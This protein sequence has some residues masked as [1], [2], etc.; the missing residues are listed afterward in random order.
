MAKL[1]ALSLFEIRLWLRTTGFWLTG[2]AIH[3]Y[4]F[5]PWS[6]AYLHTSHAFSERILGQGLLIGGLLILFTSAAVM[7]RDQSERTEELLEAIPA[8]NAEI[9]FARWLSGTA[10][11]LLIGL[12]VFTL[13]GLLILL[14]DGA[15]LEVWPLV[16]FY[17]AHYVPAVLFLHTLGMAAAAWIRQPL[18]LFPLLT[19]IWAGA[20]LGVIELRKDFLYLFHLTGIGHTVLRVSTLAGIF[21]FESHLFWQRMFFTGLT[22]LLIAN[23]I[24]VYRAQRESGD[25][26]R[27][28]RV[29]RS[30]VASSVAVVLVVVS[31]VGYAWYLR[32]QTTTSLAFSR[33]AVF[34]RGP[35]VIATSYDLNV[36]FEDNDRY[37]VHA[38]VDVV[39]ALDEP[40][41]EV[42]LL[43]PG[44]CWVVRDDV[45]G[46]ERAEISAAQ[47]PLAVPLAPGE[48]TTVGFTYECSIHPMPRRLPL[49]SGN[50]PIIDRL[51]YPIPPNDARNVRRFSVRL[52]APTTFKLALSIPKISVATG[53]TGREITHYAGEAVWLDAF[54]G[55]LVYEVINGLEAYYY[56][57]HAAA[58]RNLAADLAER[59]A[60][61]T[62]WLGEPQHVPGV[63]PIPAVVETLNLSARFQSWESDLG[64]INIPEWSMPDYYGH[65]DPAHGSLNQNA[66]ALWWGLNQVYIPRSTTFVVQSRFTAVEKAAN[67][68]LAMLY[69]AA[70]DEE[71]A[72]REI[73]QKKSSEQAN[74]S[75]AI[76]LSLHDLH[77][78]LGDDGLKSVLQALQQRYIEAVRN[79]LN[80]PAARSSQPVSETESV[81]FF[82]RTIEALPGGENVVARAFQRLPETTVNQIRQHWEN[83]A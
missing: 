48:Q 24:L 57:V 33:T 30:L 65:I 70:H 42:A 25:A 26:R 44:G 53:E 15:V 69:L 63:T 35:D 78:T 51:G 81:L 58:A 54:G 7:L 80:S 62:S 27:P 73:E 41:R 34:S 19:G 52:D 46:T 32:P 14:Q 23:A 28:S 8:T 2:L 40:L 5:P 71:A 50:I 6:F 13:A 31:S 64:F 3:L 17:I 45:H 79:A 83:D 37:T 38:S 29:R 11:W 1:V 56:P 43:L 55:P 61:Y 20:G 36:R 47:F 10:M 82:L 21:P 59:I 74:L 49:P 18:L 39:N 22:L 72:N 4:A 9:F 66:L 75:A 77:Q 68:Y 16:S 76:F 60:F 12:E 67:E